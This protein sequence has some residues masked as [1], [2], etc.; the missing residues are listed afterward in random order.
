LAALA[1]PGPWIGPLATPT[2]DR[3]AK[4]ADP[5]ERRVDGHR[6]ALAAPLRVRRRAREQRGAAGGKECGA[7]K[8]MITPRG[9]PIEGRGGRRRAEPGASF[10]A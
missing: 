7:D 2:V 8:R 1:A 4:R 5:P 3:I 9:T 6:V 10:V